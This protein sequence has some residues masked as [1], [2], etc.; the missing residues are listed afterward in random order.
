LRIIKIG[1]AMSLGVCVK[2]PEG[3]VLAA[4]SRVTLEA[5]RRGRPAIPINFDNATK[6]LSF[7][8]PHDYVGAVTYGAAVIGQRTANSFVPEFE[9]RVLAHLEDRQ[10]IQT[11]A[12]EMSKF[13]MERWSESMPL[14]PDYKGVP[15]TFLVGGYSLG[16]AYGRMFIFNI[17]HSPDPVEQ[18]AGENNFGMNWG[19]Q[20][21]IASRIVHGF[22]PAV[23]G[24][25]KAVVN[26]DKNQEAE[27]FKQFR[28]NLEFPIPYRV[29]PL[30]DCV[31]LAVFLIGTTMTAQR[32]AIGLRGVGGPIDVAIV[33]RTK[34]LEHIKRKEIRVDSV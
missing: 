18:N 31:D 9:E 13:F 19:G 4:D 8:K 23:P 1:E 32:L 25:I 2:G 10:A 33:T 24:I 3:I 7:S 30:Q 22:D 12:N 29:L 20:L 28:E 34:G 26:L 17:P 15:M 5:A 11:Y 14:P 27:L 6:L 16:E 21:E